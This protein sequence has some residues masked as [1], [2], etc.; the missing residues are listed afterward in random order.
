VTQQ[1][2]AKWL[3]DNLAYLYGNGGIAD[4]GPYIPSQPR[5]LTVT[6]DGVDGFDIEWDAPLSDG[7]TELLIYNI[8]LDGVGFTDATPPATS[9]NVDAQVWVT[10]TNAIGE[11]GR[12]NTVTA[13]I[14][15]SDSSGIWGDIFGG[16]W[17]G[18][19]GRG[20]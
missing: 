2:R 6:Y 14:P 11:S 3:K 10:A 12:S 4:S 9:V 17:G 5:N 15:A 20:V 7:G 13:T 8:Y 18:I 1:A 19:Y 16:I